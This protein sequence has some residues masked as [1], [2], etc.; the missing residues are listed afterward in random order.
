MMLV[1]VYLA[2]YVPE[3][4]RHDLLR[5]LRA[6]LMDE[7]D[8]RPK[9][10]TRRPREWWSQLETRVRNMV[11]VTDYEGMLF[12]MGNAW[13][14]LVAHM[15]NVTCVKDMQ[16]WFSP[17][18]WDLLETTDVRTHFGEPGLGYGLDEDILALHSPLGR[19]AARCYHEGRRLSFYAVSALW[20]EFVLYRQPTAALCR[21][22][23]PTMGP[24]CFDL[25][26][27]PRPY[28]QERVYLDMRSDSNFRPLDKAT[29]RHADQSERAAAV[30]GAK[31]HPLMME[32]LGPGLQHDS[33]DMA[34]VMHG[35]YAL[36]PV[37]GWDLGTKDFRA[38]FTLSAAPSDISAAAKSAMDIEALVG[39]QLS[40]LQNY[41]VRPPPYVKRRLSALYAAAPHP[42]PHAVS[43]AHYDARISARG[44]TAL[45]RLHRYHD[46]G[47]K[48]DTRHF[49]LCAGLTTALYHMNT[50]NAEEA[51]PALLEVVSRARELHD[52]RTVDSA[53]YWLYT[54]ARG[55]PRLAYVLDAVGLPGGPLRECLDYLQARS[56]DAGSS[57]L[58]HTVL[59]RQA[60]VGLA[61]GD[62]IAAV[63]EFIA[64]ASLVP[65]T[66]DGTIGL[67]ASQTAI[68]A[69]TLDRLG[70]ARLA[71]AA[72]DVFLRCHAR[73]CAI[74]SEVRI[75]A[76]RAIM[77]F[78]A[79][80][81]W[82]AEACL[83]VMDSFA[84]DASVSATSAKA[85]A[86]IRDRLDARRALNL[87]D[88]DVAE[89]LA[90]R[91]L[92]GSRS[93]IHGPRGEIDLDHVHAAEDLR[94]E[95]LARRGRLGD[96][97]G[98]V[99]RQ[100]AAVE[101][102]SLQTSDVASRVRLLL[103]RAELCDRAGRPVRGLAPALRAWRIA[104]R[105]RSVKLLW[106]ATVAIAD[107]LCALGDFESVADMLIA[108]LP[109]C[110]EAGDTCT[111]GK[112]FLRLADAYAGMAD[113]E[114]VTDLG[115]EGRCDLLVAADEFLD[116]ACRIF[117][118][119]GDV[120]KLV[121]VM[122][123]EAQVARALREFGLYKVHDFGS[124]IRDTLLAPAVSSSVPARHSNVLWCFSRS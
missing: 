123:K 67:T 44:P 24:L 18:A 80:R 25:G 116:R 74:A 93:S 46:L 35:W 85:L 15:W 21:S 78:D 111:A 91:R 107:G 27:D 31:V 9:V 77:L 54:L 99:H 115:P 72:C 48:Q 58:H 20:R 118:R 47:G 36:K 101:A 26:L 92:G 51:A 102:R 71:A 120:E 3:S 64:S 7:S 50:G 60:K 109:R 114:R 10:Q 40:S 105:G 32:K 52:H 62:K 13:Y 12:G 103:W 104:W 119:L 110:F 39:V 98:R 53:V 100:L 124:G 94:I 38:M 33:R 68:A 63:L 106:Q 88:L 90:C 87:G 76:R 34:R 22:R 49:Y 96:A 57:T 83:D 43:A 19:V 112:M 66:H 113:V 23:H 17:M 84:N 95:A 61:A 117:D 8:Y 79:G 29:P 86:R 81:P 6:C 28:D 45:E 37:E 97:W 59:L 82:D 122:S 11:S 16:W 1:R 69:A 65:A 41:G 14:A 89:D 42:H 75:G 30:A 2:G 70:L 121:E 5:F 4:D 73:H 55:Y 56:S 108:A